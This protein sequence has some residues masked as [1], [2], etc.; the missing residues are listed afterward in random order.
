MDNTAAILLTQNPLT[1]GAVKHISVIYHF[2]RD[3]VTRGAITVSYTP[4]AEMLADGLTK[5]LPGPLHKYCKIN[6]GI[7][8]ML[9]PLTEGATSEIISDPHDEDVYAGLT[10]LFTSVHHAKETAELKESG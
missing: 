7:R 8:A 5:L 3:C 10:A 2:V 1:N 9:T 4:T 6:L